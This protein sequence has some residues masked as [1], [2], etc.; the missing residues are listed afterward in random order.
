MG[1]GFESRAAGELLAASNIDIGLPLYEEGNRL[2]A[3]GADLIKLGNDVSEFAK[4]AISIAKIFL[5]LPTLAQGLTSQS[6]A[7]LYSSNSAAVAQINLVSGEAQIVFRSA[8]KL[9]GQFTTVKP[10]VID[11]SKDLSRLISLAT[12]TFVGL[13]GS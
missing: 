1:P 11:V 6:N 5:S 12:K 13:F 8:P 7:V 9:A 2:I 4:S 10:E 3:L